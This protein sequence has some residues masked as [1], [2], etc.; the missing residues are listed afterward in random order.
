MVVARDR[1]V[2]EDAAQ[3]IRVD[4]RAAAAVVVGIENARAGDASRARRRARQRRRPPAPGGRRRRRRDGR[5]PATGS[6][7]TWRSSAARACPMEGKGVY[8]KWDPDEQLAAHVLLDP[9]HD[10]CARRGRR[11]ARPAAGQGRVHR[12]RRRRRLRRQD[13]A[14]LA[15]GG[16]RP[17]GRAAARPRREVDRGP[18]RALHLQRA[19]A[20]PAAGG[21][22]SA[23]TTRGGCSPS[24]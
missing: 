8:A 2:A 7:S 19:R 17:L 1:Y 12:P 15:R 11:Q 20:R 9:D 6:P 21:R 10:R 18:A 3:R 14:P 5:R 16:P 23:S 13:R 24:T 4:L 22:P